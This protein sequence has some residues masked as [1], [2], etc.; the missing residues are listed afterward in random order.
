MAKITNKKNLVNSKSL[1]TTCSDNLTSNS[2]FIQYFINSSKLAI[3]PLSK[4]LDYLAV[5]GIT[6]VLYKLADKYM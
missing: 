2:T 5:S 1:L 3:V 4:M 6:I